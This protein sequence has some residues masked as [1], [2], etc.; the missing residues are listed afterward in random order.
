VIGAIAGAALVLV[1]WW[2]SPSDAE[3]V[4][5]APVGLSAATSQL[6]AGSRLLAPQPWGSWFEFASPSTP[7][8]VDPRIELYPPG[9][10]SDYLTV[11]TAGT[12][13]REILDRY[14]VEAVVVDRRTWGPLLAEMQADPSDWRLASEDED[15]VLFVRVHSTPD[16]P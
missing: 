12:G 10:W 5:E 15:G 16:V 14:G 11:R 1:P 9:V 3:L 13:W 2:R 6:P 7:L 8:F 4:T